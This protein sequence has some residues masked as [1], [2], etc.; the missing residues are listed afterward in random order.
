M[1]EL[2]FDCSRPR[3]FIPAG[4]IIASS[5]LGM[6]MGNRGAKAKLHSNNKELESQYNPSQV[7]W[8]FCSLKAKKH[9][10]DNIHRELMSDKSYTELFFLDDATAYSAG[11][12]PCTCHRGKQAKFIERWKLKNGKVNG[13]ADIDEAIS[14]ARID[15]D[16]N[17]LTYEEW[18]A[19]LPDGTMVEFKAKTY[20]VW[21]KQLLEWSLNGHVAAIPPPIDRQVIVL[22]P[23]PLVSCFG[24][25][26]TPE[27]HHTANGFGA[28]G[29]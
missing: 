17:K 19:K 14:K 11:H 13:L 25:E 8:K 16:G 9:S 18:A 21:K 12:R 7:D 24:P 28:E 29:Q 3:Q 22:T 27:V 10:G 4:E 26:F 2:L 23:R 1:F 15:S 6:L 5:S 20:L